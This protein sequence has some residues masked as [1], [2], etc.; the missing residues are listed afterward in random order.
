[1]IERD[2]GHIVFM[3]SIAGRHP[4]PNSAVY[5][6]TKAALRAFAEGL[7]GDLLGTGVRVTVLM[8]G[9]VETRLYD[10]VFGDHAKAHDVLYRDFDS[11]QPADIARAITTALDMPPNVDLTAIEIVPTKQFFGGSSIA[12]TPPPTGA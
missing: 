12:R 3:G 11:I 5:G 6:G 1:M 7:R 4:S 8:P 10:G 2:R 9:R